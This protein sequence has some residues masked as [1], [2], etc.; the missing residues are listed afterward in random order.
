MNKFT[1]GLILGACLLG[2][3][4]E[5]SPFIDTRREAGQVQPVGQSRP[6]RI[7]VCYHPLWHDETDVTQLA[8]KACQAQGKI[9]VMDDT[10]YFNCRL[11]TPNTA[12]YKCE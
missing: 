2:G 10:A 6:D 11:M 7:A 1:L 12:F 9:A 4:S 3:C 5:V 8:E